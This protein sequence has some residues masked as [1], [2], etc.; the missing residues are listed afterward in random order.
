MDRELVELG[1]LFC[2]TML[3]ALPTH[4]ILSFSGQEKKKNVFLF[5][6][7]PF[8]DFLTGYSELLHLK[9]LFCVQA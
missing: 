6:I 8:Q 4:T 9:L 5:C 3:Y 2:H 7:T 1:S